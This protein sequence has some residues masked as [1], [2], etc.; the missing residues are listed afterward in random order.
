MMIQMEF[1][2]YFVYV[3]RKQRNKTI[4]MKW[5]LLLLSFS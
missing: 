1:L 4:E 3:F 5:I 2:F